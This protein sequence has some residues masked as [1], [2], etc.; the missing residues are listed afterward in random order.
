MSDN[1]AQGRL[2]LPLVILL[3]VMGCG[4]AGILLLATGIL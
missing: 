1:E 3:I 2:P 4:L